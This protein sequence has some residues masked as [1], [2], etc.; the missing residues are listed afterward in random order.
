MAE[1]LNMK[2][3]NRRDIQEV[4]EKK[5]PHL[6]HKEKFYNPLRQNYAHVKAMNHFPPRRNLQ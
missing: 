6:L 1:S 4:L 2:C 5:Y 3:G